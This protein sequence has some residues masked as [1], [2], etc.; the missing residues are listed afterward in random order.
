MGQRAQHAAELVPQLGHNELSES[1]SRFSPFKIVLCSAAEAQE[2]I[3]LTLYLQLKCIN[4]KETYLR[5]RREKRESEN[6]GLI[7]A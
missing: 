1:I 2:L 4:V 5:K 3:K 6:H 7:Y